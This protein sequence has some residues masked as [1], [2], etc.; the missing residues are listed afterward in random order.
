MTDL[1]PPCHP[2]AAIYVGMRREV[3]CGDPGC[4]NTWDT[5]GKPVNRRCKLSLCGTRCECAGSQPSHPTE[6]DKRAEPDVIVRGGPWDP[7]PN[8]AFQLDYPTTP[9]PWERA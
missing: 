3:H 4:V 9:V 6:P 8:P 2:E 1:H 7:G 5:Y